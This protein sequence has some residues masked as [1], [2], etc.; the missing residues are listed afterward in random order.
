[1]S[2]NRF[3]LSEYFRTED[4]VKYAKLLDDIN[5]FKNEESIEG[6]D[7]NWIDNNFRLLAA[8]K[9]FKSC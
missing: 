2:E 3:N 4:T 5:K 7:I 6:M 1:M 8:T 9:N